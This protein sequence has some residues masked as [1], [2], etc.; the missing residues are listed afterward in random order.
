MDMANAL[1]TTTRFTD[2]AILKG[3]NLL[4]TFTGI[5][6]ETFPAATQA[7]LDMATAMGTDAATEGFYRFVVNER[8]HWR[9]LLAGHVEIVEQ[10]LPVVAQ[11]LLVRQP[12]VTQVGKVPR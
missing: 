9:K 5:G 11:Q 7:M 8:V 4:L 12:P 6:K 1:Q 3:Q 2:D 10:D